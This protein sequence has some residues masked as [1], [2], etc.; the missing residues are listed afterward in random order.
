MDPFGLITPDRI[1]GFG[2]FSFYAEY[3]MYR[4]ANYNRNMFN[5][6][7]NYRKARNS[8][9]NSVSALYHQQ[10]CGN[11]GNVK[12]VSPDGHSVL[13][14]NSNGRPVTE[15]VNGPT[16]NFAD[17]RN[18]RIGHIPQDML[19]YY[20]WGTSPDDPTKWYQRL[21]GTYNGPTN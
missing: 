18:D 2:S 11:E 4:D 16:Y 3:Q 13:I 1:P 17:P 6:N 15:S 20:I 12:Y 9:D 7:V 5:Q 8:W 21:F 10:G 19:P 14:F